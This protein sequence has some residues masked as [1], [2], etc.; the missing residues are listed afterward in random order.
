[1]DTYRLY[2]LNRA[3]H[4]VQAVE[5]AGADDAAAHQ[6]GQHRDGRAMEL[7]NLDRRVGIFE[8]DRRESVG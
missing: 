5:F 3:G 7:W 6:I 1:M 8:A 2:F 4:I